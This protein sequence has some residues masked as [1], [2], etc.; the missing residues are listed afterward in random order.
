[1]RIILVAP[2]YRSSHWYYPTISTIARSVCSLTGSIAFNSH[3]LSLILLL[4]YASLF[5]LSTIKKFI[6]IFSSCII[7]NSYTFHFFQLHN[8][9][10]R[11]QNFR[12]LFWR[13]K[14]PRSNDRVNVLAR[15]N[16]LAQTNENE[17]A[18]LRKLI[19]FLC[20]R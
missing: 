6:N 8:K 17:I 20:I 12:S 10:N 16:V 5:F 15:S 7:K 13:R 11:L 14:T 9:K 4:G 2:S 19:R 1:M 18:F 3:H